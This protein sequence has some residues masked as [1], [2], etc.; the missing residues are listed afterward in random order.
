MSQPST[1][2]VIARSAEKMRSAELASGQPLVVLG[3]GGRPRAGLAQAVDVDVGQPAQLPGE[4]VDVDTGPAVD[5]GR[6]LACQDRHTH[7]A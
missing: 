5:I 4:E 2:A 1:P 6:V 7:G 3:V